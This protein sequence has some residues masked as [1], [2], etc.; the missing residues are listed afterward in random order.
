MDRSLVGVVLDGRFQIDRALGSGASGDVYEAVHL[1]LGARVAIK[2][3]KPGAADTADV[4]R[5]RF[6]RE[7]RVAARVQS[8]HVVRVFDVVSS[9]SGP[10]Y[11]VMELLTGETV[12]ERM[13]RV[14]R[15]SVADAIDYV[16]QAAEPLAELHDAGIVHRDVK[17]SNLFIC[18]DTRGRERVKLIDFGVAAFR[19]VAPG[20]ATRGASWTAAGQSALTLT[21]AL[22]GTPRFMAPE[23]VLG[24]REVDAR[25]DVWALGVTLY[26][27]LSG[28]APFDGD[29]VLAVLGQIANEEPPP[30]AARCPDVPAGLARVVHECLSKEAAVRPADARALREALAPFARTTK[31]ASM[32]TR[33]RALWAAAIVGVLVA[34]SW[35]ALRPTAAATATTASRVSL[36]QASGADVT[37]VVAVA[38]VAAPSLDPAADSAPPAHA[39]PPRFMP[40]SPRATSSASA[41]RV[42]LPPVRPRALE[43]D[44]RIE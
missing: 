12:A 35:S 6:M 24:E 28:S 40:A 38:P 19:Q 30:L 2:V 34:T 9:D 5:R 4:R 14:G 22:V 11:I 36:Q 15:L 33:R 37:P 16:L 20:H 41:R 27:L 26:A 10:T 1:A 42:A 32:V 7:A 21:A 8:D 44:D 31:A 17:P 18:R 25:A 13:A 39:P 43:Q 29:T 3:L 23:Q